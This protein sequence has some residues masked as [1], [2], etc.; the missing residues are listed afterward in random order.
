MRSQLFPFLGIGLLWLHVLVLPEGVYG[1]LFFV[2]G[3]I[4]ATAAWVARLRE[5]FQ[6]FLPAQPPIVVKI[7]YARVAFLQ[8][9]CITSA[10]LLYVL[11]A[12]EAA[13]RVEAVIY[14]VEQL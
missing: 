6:P 14:P 9:P 5:F 4:V 1:C 7:V 12:F 3:F 2:V 10:C 11:H 8:E 13:R